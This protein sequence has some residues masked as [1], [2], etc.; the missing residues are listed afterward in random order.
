MNTYQPRMHAL[1]PC[2]GTGARAGG[3]MPKQYQPIKGEPM[4]RHT[5]RAF[6]P[7]LQTAVLSKAFVVIADTDTYWDKQLSASINQA[8]Q[9]VPM[10]GITRAQTVTKALKHLL[11]T[12]QIHTQDWVLVHDAA[13]CIITT[14]AIEKLI[15]ACR[16][17]AVGGL[18]AVPLADTLKEADTPCSEPTRVKATAQ[19]EGR[20]LAQ[21]PQM[22]RAQALLDALMQAGD[23]VTD[24]SSAMER[25]GHAP[26]L[27]RGEASNLKVTYAEDFVIAAAI[28]KARTQ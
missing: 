2:G 1:I 17:D 13:R 18:L 8:I 22:F 19:R 24:E 16:D 21:T 27:V 14:E 28:L 25:A 6:E 10:A 15:T 9:A 5:L 23:T 26:L 11:S 7:L 12:A 20:W 3:E 4:V